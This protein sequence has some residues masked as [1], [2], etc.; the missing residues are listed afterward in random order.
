VR[1]V[2]LESIPRF[3]D[4]QLKE[5]GPKRKTV[6]VLR[7][8]NRVYTTPFMYEN[9]EVGN[10]YEIGLDKGIEFKVDDGFITIEETKPISTVTVVGTGCVPYGYVICEWWDEGEAI[11]NMKDQLVKRQRI[12]NLNGTHPSIWTKLLFGQDPELTFEKIAKGF[13]DDA[14]DC[15]KKLSEAFYGSYCF[16]FYE[17]TANFRIGPPYPKKVTVRSGCKATEDPGCKLER[18]PGD[19]TIRLVETTVITDCR[20]DSCR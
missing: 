11:G 1:Q 19:Y 4:E 3:T 6:E 14:V 7:T 10:F 8:E 20:E 17:N 2:P 16:S 13:Y 9:V 12:D 15:M 18:Y 5:L